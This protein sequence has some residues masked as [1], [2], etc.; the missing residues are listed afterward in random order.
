VAA[1]GTPFAISA[2]GQTI[3]LAAG[4]ASP[5]AAADG[6][7]LVYPT[8]FY[9]SAT[10]SAQG[11]VVRVRSGEERGNVDL[12]MQPVRAVRLSGT[13]L[14][15][16]GYAAH[17]AVRLFPAG[18]DRASA[19]ETATTLSDRAGAFSFPAVP[20]G[21]Y[22]LRVV[23]LPRPPI[24]V[25]DSNHVTIVRSGN[26]SISASALPSAGPPPPPP[27]PADATLCAEVPVA[28][29]DMDLSGMAVLLR[30]GLR[31]SGRVEFDG[32]GDRPDPAT[33]ANLRIMLDPADGTS[34]PDEVSLATG[35]IDGNGQFTTYG[36]PPGKYFVRVS[37]LPGWFLK[38]ALYE[39]RDL[40][41]VSI[42]LGTSDV[43][44]VVLTFTDR[45]SSIAGTVRDG[46]IPDETAVVFAFPMD[47]AEWLETGVA[48]R[49][50]RTAR[51]NRDGAYLFPALPPGDYYL[52]AVKE[53]FV[54][55]WQDPEFL[56]SISRSA[57]Q[58]HVIEGERSSLDLRTSSVR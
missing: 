5:V 15:P 14:A 26:V 50:M 30:T 2:G 52:V 17:V 20:P 54:G 47:T 57:Q 23:R 34:L 39:G 13:L 44:G 35:R 27:I 19:I 16:E 56:E 22:I 48:P 21:Q 10:T 18:D 12:Q 8:T 11:G 28:V 53:D 43:S 42:D 36:V 58:V 49:R 1:A 41:D 46:Q 45:P 38:G 6:S 9:P 32:S 25:D 37:G 29:G 55:E 40:A 33:L 31:I 3:S 4:T 51:A 24:A 7:F